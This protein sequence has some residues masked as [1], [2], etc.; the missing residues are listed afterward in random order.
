MRTYE[1]V[2]ELAARTTTYVDLSGSRDLRRALHAHLGA[3]LAEDLVVGVTSQDGGPAGR[4][5]GARPHA[6]FAPDRMRVRSEQWGR[7][8]LDA[9]W[10]GFAPVVEQRVDVRVGTGPHALRD[11]WLEVL[12]GTSDPRTCHVVQL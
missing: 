6:L 8:G 7:A 1:E 10:Q 9:A 4:L 3:Q 12:S 11:A 2:G 5:E